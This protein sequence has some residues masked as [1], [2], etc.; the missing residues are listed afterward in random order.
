MDTI[1]VAAARQ[2][3]AIG[4]E[5]TVR[6]WVRTRRDS[7]SGFSFLE[8]ND[9]SCQG[10]LQ[11]V[12]DAVLPNY[13]AE[14]KKLSAGCSV[15]VTGTVNSSPAQGQATELKAATVTVAGLSPVESYPLQKKQHSWEFLRGIAHLRPRT[16]TFGAIARIRNRVS[17]SIHEFFQERGFLYIHTPIVTGS[18]CEGAGHLFRVTTLDLEKP[19]KADGVVDYSQDFFGR[20]SYLTVSG[21]LQL[22]TF[23]CGLGNVYTF[24]PTF[25]AENSNTTR[26]LAEFWMVEPEMAFCDLEGDMTIA[27]AFLKRIVGDVL[28]QCGEDLAFINQRISDTVIESLT[29]L[30]TSAF[31]RLAYTD[32]VELLQKSGEKFDYPVEWGHDLQTEHERFLTEKQFQGPV[33]VYNYPRTLKPFYM[34]CND[35]NRTVAAMDVLVPGVGEIIGGSQREERLD[36]LTQR[37]ADQGLAA[38]HYEWYLDL[39]RYGTV[40]HA[41]FGL[42]LDRI[43]HF[44]TG[45]Q[46]IRDVIPFPRFPGSIQY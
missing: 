41:G 18:D 32:A 39:R 25:R 23:A 1:T 11:V 7:K 40:P 30:R 42:G 26:H 17:M 8:L 34:R 14:I 37:M 19:P 29:K 20:P 6:G 5:V 4:R 36:V 22:E 46:N 44:I 10:N 9:G 28:D 3:D 31:T 21:Q 33:I 2:A 45:M 38:E 24:G 16:N 43:V 13:E 12:A 15:I 35:D 27:E